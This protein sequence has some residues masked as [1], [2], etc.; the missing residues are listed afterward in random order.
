MSGVVKK[1]ESNKEW[2]DLKIVRMTLYITQRF[3]IDR[4]KN[5][6]DVPDFAHFHYFPYRGRFHRGFYPKSQKFGT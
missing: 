2:F 5:G 1:E 4:P 3:F 6:P